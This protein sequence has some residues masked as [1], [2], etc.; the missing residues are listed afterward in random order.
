[1]LKALNKKNFKR[2]LHLSLLLAAVLFVLAGM[3]GA[4]AEDVSQ[5]YQSDDSLQNGTIVRIKPGD[6]A[7]VEALD[8]SKE[9]D[10]FGVVIS[11]NETPVSL[12]DPN[13]TEVFVAT[14]GRYDVL[15]T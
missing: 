2:A 8:Q 7:K 9:S 14:Q 1:M 12:S 3:S 13:Q 6:K 10:M 11:S 5:G 15:V 4:H